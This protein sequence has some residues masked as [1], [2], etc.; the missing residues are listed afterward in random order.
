M[1][2]TMTNDCLT[3]IHLD[4]AARWALYRRL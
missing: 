1:N 4:C 2:V 3:D